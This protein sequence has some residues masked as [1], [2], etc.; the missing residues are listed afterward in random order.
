MFEILY[1]EYHGCRY[2][3]K[4]INFPDKQQFL[5]LI[6][7]DKNKYDSDIFEP[8]FDGQASRKELFQRHNQRAY[9][10]VNNN[11]DKMTKFDV[12]KN[13]KLNFESQ[14]Y[15]DKNSFVFERDFQGL[16]IRIINES[17]RYFNIFWRKYL[18]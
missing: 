17:W 6:L 12:G 1:S 3:M 15:F 10:Y 7:S 8:E 11:F 16:Q 2:F 9:D 5:Q 4:S 18:W 14:V 13:K